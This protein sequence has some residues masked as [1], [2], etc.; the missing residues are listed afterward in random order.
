M[1]AKA[2]STVQNMAPD[3]HDLLLSIERPIT[4][5]KSTVQDMA[6][7]TKCNDLIAENDRMIKNCSESSTKKSNQL[8]TPSL[9]PPAA[10]LENPLAQAN[11]KILAPRLA[12]SVNGPTYTHL[13]QSRDN[14]LVPTQA[15]RGCW[16]HLGKFPENGNN[17]GG[18]DDAAW[19]PYLEA[20]SL[21]RNEYP[22]IEIDGIKPQTGDGG[23]MNNPPCWNFLSYALIAI[24]PWGK[25]Q[26]RVIYNL[27]L[28][29]CPELKPN[30]DSFRHSLATNDAFRSNKPYHRLSWVTEPTKPG[31][32]K[33]KG[34]RSSTKESPARSGLARSNTTKSSLGKRRSE[35]TP[36]N[37]YSAYKISEEGGSSSHIPVEHA[38]GSPKRQKTNSR[39]KSQ[40][41][42]NQTS[43]A[44][45]MQD[46]SDL[47]TQVQDC[48]QTLRIKFKGSK[49][50]NG[51]AVE[52]VTHADEASEY[53]DTKSPV[54]TAPAR[55]TTTSPP[56]S[57]GSQALED[58]IERLRGLKTCLDLWIRSGRG[59]DK[60]IFG[61]SRPPQEMYAQVRY[62]L[63]LAVDE[64]RKTRCGEFLEREG[65]A[66]Y[67][68]CYPSR[69]P[70]LP[71]ARTPLPSGK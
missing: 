68:A 7:T 63:D 38:T 53:L 48:C 40:A 3:A 37:G 4:K 2:S 25:L 19:L 55:S 50:S 62:E 20:L 57:S 1:S 47:S 15:P 5:V 23:D 59:R 30:N 56:I 39:P 69:L 49:T 42:N 61:T 33:G 44:P 9:T 32:M 58:R 46:T 6:M 29:W 67:Q 10:K 26:S 8:P 51:A 64:M 36:L 17:D 71:N 70:N 22:A 14:R 24:S 12:P 60:I 35:W 45:N 18:R 65:L 66:A 16:S 21:R 54:M 34:K 28:A 27:A 11:R 52:P 13:I 43:Q 31:A 41:N